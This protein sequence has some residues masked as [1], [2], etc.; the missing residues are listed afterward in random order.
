[1]KARFLTLLGTTILASIACAGARQVEPL[2]EISTDTPIPTPLPTATPFPTPQPPANPP[3][4][5]PAD[6]DLR[7]L[8]EYANEMQPLLVEAGF[9]LQQDGEI[10]KASEEGNDVVLCDGRLAA[11]NESMKGIMETVRSISPPE[12]AQVIHDLV[13]RSGEAW[14]EALDNVELFCDTGNQ[15][16]K[17]P[18]VLKFWEAAAS[19]QDAGNRFWLLLMAKGVEDWVQR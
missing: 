14:T 9:L 11:D 10:L 1:M 12:D 13:L 3:S 2:P 7:D 4:A 8:V 6:S 19:L 16:Y 5:L 18:A 17:V 15:L